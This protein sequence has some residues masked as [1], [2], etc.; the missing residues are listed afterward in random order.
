MG[1]LNLQI[2]EVVKIYFRVYINDI[3]VYVLLNLVKLYTFSIFMRCVRLTVGE[4]ASKIKV[5]FLFAA[6]FPMLL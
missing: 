4:S 2:T 1:G 3:F 5:V 6:K